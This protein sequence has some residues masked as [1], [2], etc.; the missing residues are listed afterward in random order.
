MFYMK[1][2]FLTVPRRV[3]RPSL[4]RDEKNCYVCTHCRKPFKDNANRHRHQVRRSSNDN[5]VKFK[6]HVNYVSGGM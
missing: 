3:G 1:R 2:S 4:D 5:L 6:L